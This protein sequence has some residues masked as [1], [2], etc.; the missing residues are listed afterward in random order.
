MSEVNQSEILEKLREDIEDRVAQLMDLDVGSFEWES[1]QKRY[2]D[3]LLSLF[4]S[5]VKEC[6]GEKLDA[7]DIFYGKGEIE[8]GFETAYNKAKD[9]ILRRAGIDNE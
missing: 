2:T 4:Q 8:H 3:Q 1:I 6:V 7:Q 9:E 5:Y